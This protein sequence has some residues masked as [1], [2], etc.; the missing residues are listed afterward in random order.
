MA[1]FCMA[2]GV[3]P[4]EYWNLTQFEHNAFVKAAKAAGKLK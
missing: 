2:T 4:S 3:Q 1:V